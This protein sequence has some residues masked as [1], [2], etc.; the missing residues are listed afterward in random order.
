MSCFFSVRGTRQSVFLTEWRGDD[1]DQPDQLADDIC[2][3]EVH[4]QVRLP[5]KTPS[6]SQVRPPGT[7]QMSTGIKNGIGNGERDGIHL[8]GKGIANGMDS[9]IGNGF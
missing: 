3:N 7:G 2:R 5:S 6:E 4:P 1:Q 8:M 9:W